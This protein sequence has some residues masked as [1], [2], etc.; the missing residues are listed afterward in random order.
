M[1]GFHRALRRL[2]NRRKLRRRSRL[3][4]FGACSAAVEQLEV[5]QLLTAVFNTQFGAETLVAACSPLAA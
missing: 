5:R 1:F 3:F 4:P 2:Q